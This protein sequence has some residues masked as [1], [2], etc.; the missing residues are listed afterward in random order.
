MVLTLNLRLHSTSCEVTPEMVRAECARSND[1][2]MA[3]MRRLK[4][5]TEPQLQ[6]WFAATESEAIEG[7]GRWVP[8]D[9]VH[10]IIPASGDF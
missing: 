9:E 1:T 10:E 7:K 6:Q 5:H 8:V 3:C 2:M 4:N